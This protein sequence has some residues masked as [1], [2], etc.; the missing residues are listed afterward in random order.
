ML[1]ML[2]YAVSFHLSPIRI[3]SLALALSASAKPR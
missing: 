1:I 2:C 3:L